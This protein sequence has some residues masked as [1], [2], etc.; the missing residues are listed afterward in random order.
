MRSRIIDYSIQ[1][2]DE[3]ILVSTI[4]LTAFI[5]SGYIRE[6]F[7]FNYPKKLEL[8]TLKK[9]FSYYRKTIWIF[10]SIF[11]IIFKIL[12]FKFKIYQKG[13]LPIYDIN[14][15]ISGIFKWLLLFGL[16]AIS[17]L[18]IFYEF[19]YYKKFFVLS[20]F[21]VILETFFTSL[22]MLSRG[23]IFNSFA[24]LYGV[25]NFQIG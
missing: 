4:G 13:L 1:L 16:S 2:F 5:F 21:L 18:L 25:Y 20:I 11:F 14:F 10:F 9:L 22:S 12:N 19:N 8:Q 17:S 24:I 23:M 3:S 15:L 7:F 6:F